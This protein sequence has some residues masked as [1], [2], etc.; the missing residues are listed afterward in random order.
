MKKR[1]SDI[2]FRQRL[3]CTVGK[4]LLS[5]FE[6]EYPELKT[7]FSKASII[8]KL[9]SIDPSENLCGAEINSTY[10][11]IKQGFLHDNYDIYLLV[12]DTDDGHKIGE[13]LRDYFS[14]ENSPIKF[15]NVYVKE[16]KGLKGEERI[17]FK[18]KGL[19]EIANTLVD[20]SSQSPEITIINATGGYK[21]Q[22]SF[23]TL[24][25]E[26]LKIPV[27][28]MFEQFKE[29]IELPPMPVSFDY[30]LWMENYDLLESL[31]K[32]EATEEMI[33]N[34]DPQLKVLF[35][36]EK[37]GKEKIYGLT[38]MGIIFHKS[39]KESF[40]KDVNNLPSQRTSEPNYIANSKEPNS[41]K[42]DAKYNISKKIL[43]IPYIKELRC[44]Y[45]SP[46]SDYKTK[47]SF[48]NDDLN[49]FYTKN[50]ETIGF[51]AKTTAKTE[52]QKVALKIYIE[53]EMKG[54]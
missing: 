41:T 1:R 14:H 39:F 24:I 23:A 26:I 50:G 42:F 54:W 46:N 2:M 35:D 13:I 53:E 5:N 15:V 29:I 21:A 52:N 25:G 22:I 20:L 32:L 47:A 38:P 4:S 19:K 45:Y 10:S 28:Y 43:K 37:G 6:R 3:I 44:N 16:I 12:S 49:I 40:K 9:L 17:E 51:V 8:N 7:N 30:S 36:F 11:I 33:K 27:Y 34:A 48:K 31:D 18:N